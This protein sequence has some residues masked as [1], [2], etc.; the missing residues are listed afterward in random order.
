MYCTYVVRMTV[1]DIVS[2]ITNK[3]LQFQNNLSKT[4]LDTFT[5]EVRPFVCDSDSMSNSVDI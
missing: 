3:T 4:I 2:S 5:N 1:W